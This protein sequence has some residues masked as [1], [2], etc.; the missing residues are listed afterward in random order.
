MNKT[1][2][3]VIGEDVAAE[4]RKIVVAAWGEFEPDH[5]EWM[6]LALVVVDA[7]TAMYKDVEWG[8][9]GKGGDPTASPLMVQIHVGDKRT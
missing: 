3:L 6:R 5:T 9:G 8:D 4:R 2:E 7:I 1:P